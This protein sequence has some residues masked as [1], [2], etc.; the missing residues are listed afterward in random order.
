MSA[1]DNALSSSAMSS[2][3][4]PPRRSK[5]PPPLPKR[6]E[7]VEVE[8]DWLEKEPEDEPKKKRAK[9]PP[10]IPGA[11]VHAPPLPVKPSKPP[12]PPRHATMEVDMRELVVVPHVPVKELLK[13]ARPA[14]KPIPREDDDAPPR[15][16]SR[17][18]PSHRKK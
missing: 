17:P 7:T 16:H 13:P 6:R 3:K 8:L 10:P 18:P 9:A 5:A 14:V 1:S 2:Q 15:K 4:P 12:P 11:R